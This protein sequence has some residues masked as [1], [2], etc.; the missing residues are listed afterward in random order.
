MSNR[1]HD[2]SVFHIFTC[3]CGK[4]WD[5]SLKTNASQVHFRGM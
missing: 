1:E 3:L 5:S 4:G 2:D